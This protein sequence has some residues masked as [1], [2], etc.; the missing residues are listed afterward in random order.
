MSGNIINTS[1][2]RTSNIYPEA[3]REDLRRFIMPIVEENFRNKLR[4]IAVFGFETSNKINNQLT[5]KAKIYKAYNRKWYARIIA[6]NGNI[7]FS[8]GDGYERKAGAI[9][10]VKALQS[11]VLVIEVK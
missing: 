3:I 5:M 7:L 10:A 11:P 1:K 4:R 9:K 6:K 2:H 8:S